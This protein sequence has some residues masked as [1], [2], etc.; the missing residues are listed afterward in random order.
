MTYVIWLCMKAIFWQKVE[1]VFK[2]QQPV[3]EAIKGVALSALIKLKCGSML[4]V[5]RS[6]TALKPV[7]SEGLWVVV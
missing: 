7:L 2:F 1:Q 4:S 5:N 6:D 3:R